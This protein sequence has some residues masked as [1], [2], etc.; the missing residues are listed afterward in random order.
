MLSPNRHSLIIP[1]VRP[2]DTGHYQCT[3]SNKAG[4]NERD[5]HLIVLGKFSEQNLKK[6]GLLVADPLII[7]QTFYLI[8]C[9]LKSLE[10]LT[11]TKINGM[12]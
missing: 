9:I 1:N 2:H 7:F 6:L 8:F 12:A 4:R 10:N 11:S 3:A 5:F